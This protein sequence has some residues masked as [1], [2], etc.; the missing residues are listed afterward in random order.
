M[1][2]RVV[3]EFPNESIREIIF[4]TYRII[5]EITEENIIIL[6][7]IHGSKLLDDRD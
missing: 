3:P 6:S 4:R 1:S 2:G 7:V 5:Y